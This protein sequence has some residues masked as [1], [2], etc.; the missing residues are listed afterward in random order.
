VNAAG[1]SSLRTAS[2]RLSRVYH[3]NTLIITLLVLTTKTEQTR[4]KTVETQNSKHN[5][6]GNCGKSALKHTQKKTMM[7]KMDR[8]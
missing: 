5:Q 8:G 2:E 3:P 4:C 6:T 1:N 7:K